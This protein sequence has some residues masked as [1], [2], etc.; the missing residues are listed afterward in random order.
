MNSLSNL[1][2]L[3]VYNTAEMN[4]LGD[5]ELPTKRSV[6]KFIRLSS[7]VTFIHHTLVLSSIMVM[8]KIYPTYFD[9]G[10]FRNVVLVPGGTFF[11]IAFG[12]T[13][14]LG[15]YS[16]VLSLYLAKKVATAEVGGLKLATIDEEL[17]LHPL[18]KR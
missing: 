9:Q 18:N 7:I 16:M 5:G 12:A 10:Q 6:H 2:V 11:F 1:A 15:F 3:N 13:I 17:K 4:L 14:I 8:S